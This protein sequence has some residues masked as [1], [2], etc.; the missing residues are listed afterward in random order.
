MSG[1]G[2]LSKF[3]REILDAILDELCAHHVHTLLSPAD[4]DPGE[5]QIHSETATRSCTAALASLCCTSK[6]LSHLNTWRLYRTL[7]DAAVP[8]TRWALLARTLIGRPDLASLV[9]HFSVNNIDLISDPSEMPEE[10]TAYYL[11]MLR[12]TRVQ[13]PVFLSRQTLVGKAE[14]H[15]GKCL[16]QV[17]STRSLLHSLFPALRTMKYALWVQYGYTHGLLSFP[18]GSLPSLREVELYD[19]GGRRGE[20]DFAFLYEVGGLFQAAP[21]I[22]YLR[23]RHSYLSDVIVHICWDHDKDKCTKRKINKVTRLE[24]LACWH[25]DGDLEHSLQVVPNVETLVYRPREADDMMD[26]VVNPV[27]MGL[28]ILKVAPKLK[29]FELALWYGRGCFD[30]EHDRNGYAS[31][32]R[33][34]KRVLED[35]GIECD[36]S[37]RDPDSGGLYLP[38]E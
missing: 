8:G 22:E 37:M 29:R 16:C 35:N 13:S 34:A 27:E 9:S 23:I 36:F 24:I 38:V 18:A 26:E 12:T 32:L 11:E 5:P 21:E 3:P 4:P 28:A 30:D 14:Q 31:S 15:D 7:T 6:S 33:E 17:N 25:K 20:Y 1:L 2:T 10:V 19:I